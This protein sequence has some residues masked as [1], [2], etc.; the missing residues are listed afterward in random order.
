MS[1][2]WK[3]LSARR[4]KRRTAH[5]QSGSRGWGAKEASRPRKARPPGGRMPPRPPR[6]SHA[7]PAS[8]SSQPSGLRPA[9][10]SRVPVYSAGTVVRSSPS[11]GPHQHPGGKPR[12]CVARSGAGHGLQRAGAADRAR[13]CRAG[14]CTV[15]GLTRALPGREGLRP[16][17]RQSALCMATPSPPGAT[18]SA[19]L[20]DGCK[21]GP[22]ADHVRP[23]HAALGRAAHERQRAVAAARGTA[24]W[25]R[26][27]GAGP[28]PRGG[29]VG[30]AGRRNW[31]ARSTGADRSICRHKS[32]PGRAAAA[33]PSA[34]RPLRRAGRRAGCGDAAPP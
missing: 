24:G 30:D 8:V 19:Q 10:T 5:G 25:V 32:V 11:R 7:T 14:P 1:R 15:Q 20:G 2:A 16:P 13:G 18:L 6:R 23:Q 27:P 4:P 29:A 33:R 28:P 26:A 31:I 21:A 12:Q 9:A 22:S 17:L 3:Q 34:Q